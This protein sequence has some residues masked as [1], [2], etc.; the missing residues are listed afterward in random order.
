LSALS[1]PSV[2]R[3]PR[4]KREPK[5]TRVSGTSARMPDWYYE[6]KPCALSRPRFVRVPIRDRETGMIVQPVEYRMKRIAEATC[7]SGECA[8]GSFTFEG[9]I[10]HLCRSCGPAAVRAYM[11]A[12]PVAAVAE[13]AREWAFP[14]AERTDPNT[15]LV[16]LTPDTGPLRDAL[17]NSGFVARVKDK[18]VR[19]AG[20]RPVRVATFVRPA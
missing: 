14:A 20:F 18:L 4:E 7:E 16:R 19:K 13:D 1:A 9:K 2:A 15:V 3:P 17:V 6:E 12:E 11:E 8:S 10:F 5:S